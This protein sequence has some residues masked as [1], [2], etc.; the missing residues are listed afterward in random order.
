[1]KNLLKNL[2]DKSFYVYFPEEFSSENIFVMYLLDELK[3]MN[4][5]R[6]ITAKDKFIENTDI[7]IIDDYILTG[8]NI[9]KTLYEFSKNNDVN[10]NF[11][12]LIPYCS[13]T[14][15][16]FVDESLNNNKIYWYVHEKIEDVIFGDRYMTICGEEYGSRLP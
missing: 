3:H 13:I 10:I 1:M 16:N 7:S 14:G 5:K 8:Q 12:L 6:F 9:D 15:Y 2:H 4:I 11:H